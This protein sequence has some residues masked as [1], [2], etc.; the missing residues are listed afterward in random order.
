MKSTFMLAAPVLVYLSIYT[1]GVVVGNN[2]FNYVAVYMAACCAMLMLFFIT[3]H[4]DD[5]KNALAA[6]GL[7]ACVFFASSYMVQALDHKSYPRPAYSETTA[8]L[9]NATIQPWLAS[10][11]SDN[12]PADSKLPVAP[13]PDTAKPLTHQ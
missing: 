11:A 7:G 2:V 12:K 1:V 8:V 6:L 4:N 3:R 13:T 10:W 9:A 5:Y